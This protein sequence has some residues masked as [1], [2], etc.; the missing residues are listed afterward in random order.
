[1][2]GEVRFEAQLDQ[3]LQLH[4]ILTALFNQIAAAPSVHVF[5]RMQQL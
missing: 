1:M 4:N 5:L 3:C 2:A